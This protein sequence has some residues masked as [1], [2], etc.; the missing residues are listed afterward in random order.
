VGRLPRTRT[1]EGAEIDIRS[2]HEN[3]LGRYVPELVDALLAVDG[4][5]FVV[6]RARRPRDLVFDAAAVLERLEGFG[7]LAAP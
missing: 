4:E 3:P 1:C 5:R 2:R 7:D 6:E